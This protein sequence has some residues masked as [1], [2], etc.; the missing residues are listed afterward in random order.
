M[1]R[2][3][4]MLNTAQNVVSRAIPGAQMSD[5][6][7]LD[8]WIDGRSFIFFSLPFNYGSMIISARVVLKTSQDW[9]ADRTLTLHKVSQSWTYQNGWNNQPTIGAVAGSTNHAQATA[10]GDEY[11]I[12]VT[13]HMQEAANGA[14]W[15]GWALRCD[16]NSNRRGVASS[17]HPRSDY[18]PRLEVVWADKPY[19]PNDLHPRG[20]QVVSDQK[21]W[22]YFNFADSEGATTMSGFQ[23]QLSTNG[24]FS[25]PWYDTTQN[26]VAP[27]T[28]LADLTG[29]TQLTQNQWYWWRVRVRDDSNLWSTWSD[30][31][32]FKYLPKP[33]ITI[34]QPTATTYD[35]TPTIEWTMSSGTQTSFQ[36]LLYDVTGGANRLAHDSGPL[37]G[38]VMEYT[39]PRNVI[40]ESNHNWQII[41]NVWD[42]QAR[43]STGGIPAYCQATKNFVWQQSN[44]TDPVTD[45]IATRDTDGPSY[46]L[47]WRMTALDS[48]AFSV[49]RD[50]TM[51]FM[52][53]AQEFVDPNTPG[54]YR[55]KDNLV[56]GRR[57]HTWKV[58]NHL[59]H[60]TSANNLET[61]LKVRY[62]CPW[63]VSLNG[64]G[65]IPLAN[66]DID[67][68]LHEV[69]DVV[70][71]LYGA[72]V[73]V[74][75][76]LQGFLGTCTAEIA[77]DFTPIGISAEELVEKFMDMRKN[78]KCALLWAD[79]AIACY[80]YNCS[81][82]PLT[83][84]DGRTDYQISFGFL[85]VSDQRVTGRY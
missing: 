1:S 60:I 25:S 65:N 71:P 7:Q 17:T 20:D 76:S 41:V 80:I 47:K 24:D 23:L 39:I 12:D 26:A 81:F 36:V 61:S 30:P 50:G 57:E 44:Q 64:L 63:L 72:P 4:S 16:A 59:N 35:A 66:A 3:A 45:L 13:Q 69:S 73:L 29:F 79:Q 56:S 37:P 84:A 33:T 74:Q 68:G 34:T 55:Y 51:V 21:S 27:S 6:P 28:H 78:P 9:D 85:E 77:N 14:A 22:L 42:D 75:Q 52:G 43:V 58:M 19:Q 53:P 48:D 40:T 31:V 2:S 5:S 70:Q 83:R 32:R 46:T 15:F 82:R 62:E 38:N 67:P 11:I 49:W 10:A 8:T 54:G 18:R